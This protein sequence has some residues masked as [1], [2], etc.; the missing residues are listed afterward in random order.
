MIFVLMY[1]FIS[2]LFKRNGAAP[3]KGGKGGGGG[4]MNMFMEASKSKRFMQTVNVKFN[5]V[6][7]MQK[8]K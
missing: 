1:F 3:P 5:D 8:A 2:S 4:S 7:G 6:M